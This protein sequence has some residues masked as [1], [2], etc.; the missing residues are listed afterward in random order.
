MS[1]DAKHLY[2][3]MPAVYRLR[4]ADAG[5]TLKALLSVIAEQTS[6]CPIRILQHLRRMLPSAPCSYKASRSWHRCRNNSE[7]DRPADRSALLASRW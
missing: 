4:D 3:L 6:V 2:E 5:G 1:F 7:G